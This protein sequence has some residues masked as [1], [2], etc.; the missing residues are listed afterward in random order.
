MTPDQYRDA[1][2]ALG[3]TQNEAGRLFGVHAGSGRRWASEGP[4]EAVAMLLRIADRLQWTKEYLEKIS[5]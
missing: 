4:P 2:K 3:L 1:L 5:K